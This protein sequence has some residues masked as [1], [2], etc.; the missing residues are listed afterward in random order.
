MARVAVELRLFS[1]RVCALLRLKMTTYTCPVCGFN[2][3]ENP[4]EDHVICPCCGTQ[5]GYDDVAHSYRELRNIWLHKG[6]RW[7]NIEC[8]SF[9]IR[10]HWNAWDQLD[11]ALLPYDVANPHSGNQTYEVRIPARS[12]L[13]IGVNSGTQCLAS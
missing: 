6:G 1:P 3:L 2:Q 13:E 5:F 7:F 4:P 9:S 8:P 11:G 12:V 10:R